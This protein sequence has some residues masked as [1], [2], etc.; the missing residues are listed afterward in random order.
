MANP[1]KFGVFVPQGWKMDLVD[2]LTSSLDESIDA[3][4]GARRPEPSRH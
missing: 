3:K 4:G 2:M 1:V